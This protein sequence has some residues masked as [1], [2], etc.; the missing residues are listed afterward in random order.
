M[1]TYTYS[2]A[3]QSL[4]QLL[5]QAQK[6]GQVKLRSKDGKV[7]VIKPERASG[8]SPLDVPTPKVNITRE[9]ILSAIADGRERS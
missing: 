8:R 4:A 7:F 2:Q 3:R 1:M 6:D 9:D 5:E